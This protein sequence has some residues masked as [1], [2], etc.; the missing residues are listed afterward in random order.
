MGTGGP[1]SAISGEA[2]RRALGPDHDAAANQR[3]TSEERA[4]LD[5]AELRAVER[6]DYY[7]EAETVEPEPVPRRGWLARL[8]GS[9][10]R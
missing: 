1:N 9:R 10:S 7:G 3:A 4:E 8:F 2:I 6:A 5:I